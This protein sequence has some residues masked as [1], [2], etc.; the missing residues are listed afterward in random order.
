LIGVYRFK[1]GFGGRIVRL[2]PAFD[3]VLLPPLYP[4]AKQKIGG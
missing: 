4:L 2:M 1:K 3:L